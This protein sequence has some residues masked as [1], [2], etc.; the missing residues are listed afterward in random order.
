MVGCMC[1]C[2]GVA[3]LAAAAAQ[4]SRAQKYREE[5]KQNAAL[6]CHLTTLPILPCPQAD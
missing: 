2:M 5:G 6:I 4:V 3:V 1:G